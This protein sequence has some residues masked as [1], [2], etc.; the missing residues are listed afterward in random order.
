MGD[1]STGPEVIDDFILIK[2]DG[3]PTYNFA[4]IVDDAEMKVSHVIRG[5]EF[6]ASTP[7]YLNLYEALAIAP[8][9]FATMPHILNEQGN[10]KLGKR[11][12]AKDVLDYI[13]QGYLPDALVSFIATLGW[14]DGTTQEVFT[15][16]ELIHKFSLSRVGKSGARFDERRLGWVNSQFIRTLS[17]EDLYKKAR[18]FLPPVSK[19]HDQE[20]IKQVIALVQERVRCFSE[21]PSLTSFFFEDLPIDSSLI[22]QHKQ[23]KKLSHDEL[24]LLLTQSHAKL[25]GLE[26]FELT[27]ITDALNQLLEET[28]Q[29]PVVLFS[30]VRIATTQA[31]ASPE[32][33]PTLALL[34]KDT[35]AKR[36]QQQIAAL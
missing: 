8:P 17:I 34:G 5:Q 32:L 19:N 18:D 10:K 26:Q 30:L 9:I 15:R 7:N 16:E 28:G 11:D 12:G 31:P 24:N 35:V 3:F 14:N 25:A 27:A 22:S 2:S 29:K 23:L 4:H 6:L 1:L 13:K 20:Y 36:I 33:A 21:L